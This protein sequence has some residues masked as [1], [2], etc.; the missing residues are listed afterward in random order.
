MTVKGKALLFKHVY[1]APIFNQTFFKYF[2]IQ[3]DKA[4]G[5]ICLPGY[6]VLEAPEIKKHKKWVEMI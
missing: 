4:K 3:D 1:G 6:K 2:C 5:V